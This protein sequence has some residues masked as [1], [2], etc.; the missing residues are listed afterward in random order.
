MFNNWNL[1]ESDF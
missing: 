1:A